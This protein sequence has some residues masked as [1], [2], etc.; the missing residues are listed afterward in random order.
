MRLPAAPAGGVNVT[1]IMHVAFAAIDEPLV[2]VVPVA[3]AKS[4]AFVPEI[5]GAELMVRLDPP[6]FFTVTVWAALV[7][8]TS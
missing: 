7:V 2:H 8:V 1:L 5:D 3:I 4:E 6:V